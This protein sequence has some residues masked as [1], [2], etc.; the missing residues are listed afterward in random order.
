MNVLP[1][2][3][4]GASMIA[5]FG[6]GTIVGNAVRFTTPDTLNRAQ[7]ILITIG[8]IALSGVAGDAVGKYV[9]EDIIQANVD[10]WQA[11]K[12]A[13][14]KAGNLIAGGVPVKDAFEEAVGE[15]ADGFDTD[16]P[17]A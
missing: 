8:S 10:S 4:L 2:V 12:K 5:S 7:K 13:G 14:Q 6:T 16:L 15:L 1:F 3:K 17:G 11:G 9:A